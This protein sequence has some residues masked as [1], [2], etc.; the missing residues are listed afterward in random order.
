MIGL[1]RNAVADRELHHRHVRTHLFEE[2]QTL[3]DTMIEVDKLCFGEF[4]DV[5][6]HYG[7]N[8]CVDAKR[9]IISPREMPRSFAIRSISTLVA[10]LTLLSLGRAS[11]D[12]GHLRG[13]VDATAFVAG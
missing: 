8:I 1:K 4:V 13:F 11:G 5:D 3:Y 9:S 7:A 6:F 12:F 10:G 2:S